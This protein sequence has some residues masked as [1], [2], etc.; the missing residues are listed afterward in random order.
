MPSPGCDGCKETCAESA[1][2]G[3]DCKCGE[4]CTCGSS[5]ENADS[6]DSCPS[7]KKQEESTD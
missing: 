6:C 7:K 3:D 5:E 4:K 2:C 1:N